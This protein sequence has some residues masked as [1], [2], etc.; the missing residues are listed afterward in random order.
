M[1]GRGVEVATPKTKSDEAQKQIGSLDIVLYFFSGIA[2]FVG[3]FLIL[4]AFNMTVFQ[5]M[6]EI[7]TLRALG[8]SDRRVARGILIEAVLLALVGSV[9]GLGLGAGL[10]L[11]LVQA[12]QSFGLPVSGLDFSWGAVIAALVTGLVATIAGAAWPAVRAA[13]TPPVQAMIGTARGGRSVL[14]LRRARGRPRA[15]RA[16]RGARRP[17]LVRDGV[18]QPARRHRGDR[19]D[20]GAVPGHGPARAVRRDPARAPDGTCRCAGP[21][22]PRAGSPRTPRSR[23]PAGPRPPP[24]RCSSRCRSSSSTPPSP[25][26]FVGSVQSE[27]DKRFARDL[28][29]Q[30]LGFQEGG[31]PQSAITRRLRDQIAAMPE[32]GAVA[33]RR[34]VFLPDMPAGGPRRDRR[35]LRPRRVRPRRQDGVPGRAARPGLERTGRR[36]RGPGRV[37]REGA[38]P[39]RRRPDA[40]RRAVGRPHRAGRRDRG[41]VRGRRPG[42]P[43]VDRHHGRR[44]RGPQRL[45]ADRQGGVARAARRAGPPRAA[46]ARARLPRAGGAV[47]HGVQEEHDGR[48]QPAVRLLQRHRGDRR[49]RGRARAS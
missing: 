22:P 10:A 40:P 45:P 8:A 46:A 20:H 44:L 29:V 33:R 9:A 19:R 25:S 49:A 38:G 43:D 2:L 3:A 17:V 7:G 6:R 27:L 39:A 21:C 36:R 18:G 15:V 4:N 41:H 31:P 11:L 37:V 48:H 28:T 23:T 47:E 32:T 24:P 1:L 14:T 34:S 16:R 5:R 35:R 42:R 26:S 13:R 30:P 12:M